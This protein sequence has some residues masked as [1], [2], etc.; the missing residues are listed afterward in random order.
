MNKKHSAIKTAALILAAALLLPGAHAQ[1]DKPD[2]DDIIIFDAPVVNAKKMAL[3][4]QVLQ[5][6]AMKKFDEAEALLMKAADYPYYS[7]IETYY[8]TACLRSIAGRRD[9]AMASL[10]KSIELGFSDAEHIK[11][12]KDL[13]NIR[14]MPAFK[15]MLSELEKKPAPE[16]KKPAELAPMPVS[17]GKAEIAESNTMW[18]MAANRFVVLFSFPEADK[19]TSITTLAGPAGDLLRQWQK[20]G[21]AA[22]LHGFLYDNRDRKHSNLNPQLFPQLN[23]IQYHPRAVELGYDQGPQSL[24]TF[25]AP[26]IGNASQAIIGNNWRSLTRAIYESPLH[27]MHTA[28]LYLNHHIYFYPE[29]TDYDPEYGDVFPANTPYV[30]TSQ[31]SSGS[32][33]P[34][35]QAAAATIAAFTPETQ[36]YLLENKLLMPTFQMIFR[37]CNSTVQKKEDYLTGKAHPAVFDSKNL[38]LEKMVKMAH[39]MKTNDVPPVV[40]LKIEEEDTAVQGSDF[41]DA[42]A[43]EALFTSVSAIARVARSSKWQWRMVV[44]TAD[45]KSPDG[46]PLKFSWHVLRGDPDRVKILPLDKDGTS[47]EIL[48]SWH[49]RGKYAGSDLIGSRVDIGVFAHNGA[50]YSAPAFVT[51]YFPPNEKRVY[52]KDN[53]LLSLERQKVKGAAN[54]VDPMIV[55]PCD[56]KDTF[57]YDKN[58][59]RTGWTRTVGDKTQTFTREGFLAEKLDELGRPLEAR[60]VLYRREQKT[61]D[62]APELRVIPLK[63]VAAYTYESKDDFTGQCK[64][65]GE[66]TLD[67]LEPAG[68]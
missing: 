10:K 48:V 67:Q 62:E 64:L 66:F 21:T 30:I 35:I 14:D 40:R 38:Q 3:W 46:R 68:N 31:G 61:E 59:N 44:S 39:E 47:A 8:N 26:V 1:Q 7:E 36:K 53:K 9:D 6:A 20:E 45:T 60:V 28:D 17:N 34:F 63:A 29:N 51:W 41:T 12:D 13:D 18:L 65:K 15:E 54:Y 43:G 52:D 2:I 11:K 24:F 32:D 37:M 50:N 57:K 56:W 4:Q 16:K 33:Q 5:L 22:G 42:F 23:A 19:E 25:S 27:A 55:T 49:E 58:G